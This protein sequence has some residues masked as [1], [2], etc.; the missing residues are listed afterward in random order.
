MVL[1][2]L[3]A[4]SGV[5]QKMFGFFLSIPLFLSLVFL[6][7]FL[8]LLSCPNSRLKRGTLF[9]IIFIIFIITGFVGLV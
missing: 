6:F 7:N 2:V 8:F 9:I 3:I 5:A 4:T 1:G